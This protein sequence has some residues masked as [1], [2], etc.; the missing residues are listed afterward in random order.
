MISVSGPARL[1]VGGDLGPVALIKQILAGVGGL[2]HPANKD[3]LRA[4]QR[5][6]I[7]VYS[8]ILVLSILA[9]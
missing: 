5:S 8:S 9:S 3:A 6:S 7:H 1:Q 2:H 4:R